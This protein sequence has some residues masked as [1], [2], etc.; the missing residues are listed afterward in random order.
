VAATG[1]KK[2][3][4]CDAASYVIAAQELFLTRLLPDVLPGFFACSSLM[5]GGK[6]VFSIG[7]T[8]ALSFPFASRLCCAALGALFAM[9]DSF[10]K[11]LRRNRHD[12]VP[13]VR[14]K[15]LQMSITDQLRLTARSCVKHADNS[16]VHRSITSLFAC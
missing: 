2:A 12:I 3:A 16:S 14:I 8:I 5:P 13:S 1:N 7:L 10:R 15:H 9:I 11:E 6:P 4:P